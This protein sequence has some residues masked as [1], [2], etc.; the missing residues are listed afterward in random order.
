MYGAGNEKLGS[1][2]GGSK[3]SGKK[4]R[5]RFFDNLPAFKRLRDRVEKASK[6]TYLKGLDG[7]RIFVRY[8]YAALNTLLQGAGAIVMKKALIIL[9]SKARSRNLDFKF[10]ANIHDEW[11]VEV[12]EAH[13][14]YFGKLGVESIE[15]A[16][17][18]FKLR[19]P[20][21]GTYKVGDSWNETH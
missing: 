8:N 6:R 17:R 14:E 13:S 18:H 20:L 15:E 21:T 7:R 5:E 4:L 1:V 9:D 10:V 12:H 3:A 19:C 2:V 16:G 11:Q